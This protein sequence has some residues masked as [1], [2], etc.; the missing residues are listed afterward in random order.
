MSAVSVI[1][2]PG[3]EPFVRKLVAALSREGKTA[4]PISGDAL[5]GDLGLGESLSIV[6]W[7]QAAVGLAAIRRK[8]SEALARGALVPVV[9]GGAAPPREFE[10][11]PPVDL[12]GWT[13]DA[14]DPRWRFVVDEINLSAQ[15]NL[16]EDGSVWA[17]PDA[18][19]WVDAAP[20]TPEPAPADNWAPFSETPAS[21]TPAEE[22]P[23]EA[24]AAAAALEGQIPPE[25]PARPP[26]RA[27]FQP[28][29]VAVGA[30]LALAVT[31]LGAALI[32][33]A[34]FTGPR[35]VPANEA[36]LAQGARLAFVKPAAPEA[37]AADE[38]PLPQAEETAI[39]P[40]PALREAETVQLADPETQA[41]EDAAPPEN[42]LSEDA[43][44]VA[45]EAA[46]PAVADGAA[47]PLA[48]DDPIQSLL[49]SVAPLSEEA[50]EE[51][52]LGN[53]F[54]ECV[55]CPDMAALP[56]GGFAMGS[57]SGERARHAAEGP[58][59][60][61]DITRRFAIATRE[62][63]F[64]QW[65]A[66][67]ADGGCRAYAP[68]DHGWGRAAQP[69]VSVSFEDAQSYVAWLSRKTGQS[70]RLPS[71]AE[72]EFAA[73]AGL[74][75]AFAFGDR[76]TP[77]Q[78]NYNAAYPYGGPKARALGRPTP[79][80]SF[81]P[82]A[83]GLFD[84]HG[85]VWEWTADCWAESHEG[86]ASDGAPRTANGGVCDRRVLKGGAWNTGGWR[87]RSAHRIG[88]DAGAREFDNGFRVARDLD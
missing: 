66:C 56:V 12:T 42:P 63:T 71:E 59:T 52:Y 15:R 76:L 8:A 80:A 60:A 43:A 28:R 78:A 45:A 87:L 6:V 64:E 20:P 29:H 84:M 36:P 3:D 17:Q 82:N 22:Q 57:P 31:T 11:L 21:E 79:T 38:A 48:D 69:V 54:R 58:V 23:V 26:R 14:H 37:P 75:G 72:W 85:N 51:T 44:E 25:A 24:A 33:P 1:H 74:S 83:F 9:F 61:I 5:T 7:S 2:A 16:L 88:K 55:T 4:Q 39:A 32:A 68:P 77:Q 47:D 34:F 35:A 67:V 62:T 40:Q 53:Y 49:A 86:A 41:T 46:A 65:D 70:Y 27:G 19:A 30:S 13:G 50:A 10:D 73:R 81:P 18:D